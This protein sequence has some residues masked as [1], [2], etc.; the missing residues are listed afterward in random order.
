MFQKVEKGSIPPFDPSEMDA[1]T[2]DATY[3]RFVQIT[4][5]NI[6]DGN[7][8]GEDAKVKSQ[9]IDGQVDFECS[10]VEHVEQEEGSNE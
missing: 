9:G 5:F 6:C 4:G 2:A 1:C 10:I 7:C 8:P 3:G